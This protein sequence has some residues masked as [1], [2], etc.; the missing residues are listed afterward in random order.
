MGQ[1]EGVNNCLRQLV[2]LGEQRSLGEPTSRFLKTQ[3][4]LRRG[5]P[6]A[7]S[8]ARAEF[9]PPILQLLRQIN[10]GHGM[11]FVIKNQERDWRSRKRVLR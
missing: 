10:Q 6:F 8:A 2:A 5:V 11:C 9:H 7:R 4:Q 3:D 1:G